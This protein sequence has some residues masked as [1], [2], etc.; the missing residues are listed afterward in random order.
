MLLFPEGTG[1]WTIGKTTPNGK[2]K[3]HHMKH[4]R[5]HVMSRTG[6]F[7][8]LHSG[9]TLYQQ[10]VVEDIERH[11]TMELAWVHN[12][13]KTIRANLYQGLQD[14]VKNND[15]QKS[16]IVVVLPAYHTCSDIWYHKKYNNSM[17]IV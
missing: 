8:V 13:Q 16:G 10:Y 5:Y 11:Q 2:Y 15:V 14:A 9:R 12:D 7:N 17:A 4:L 1:G 6:S 3:L